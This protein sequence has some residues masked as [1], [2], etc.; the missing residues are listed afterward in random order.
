MLT[1]GFGDI[2]AN[3]SMEALCLIFIEMV[4]CICLAYNISCVGNLIANIRGMD[5][6][7]NNN[8]KILQHLSE[9]N[10][11]STDLS[12]KIGNYIE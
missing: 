9:K 3:T 2:S 4:S 1:V 12:C 10:D 6:E 11:L 7:K 5:I 8:L